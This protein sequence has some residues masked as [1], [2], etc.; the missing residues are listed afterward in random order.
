[1]HRNKAKPAFGANFHTAKTQ[2]G[3]RVIKWPPVRSETGRRHQNRTHDC[4]VGQQNQGEPVGFRVD[5]VCKALHRS[6]S[7]N[8][9]T[10]GSV[11]GRQ[12][13]HQVRPA[14]RDKLAHLLTDRIDSA[15][16]LDESADAS[17]GD[18]G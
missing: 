15:A 12:L 8:G 18:L 7:G 16:A 4:C 6:Y 2:P 9:S 14:G 13:A 10:H 5:P 17:K 1:M 11:L 3:C